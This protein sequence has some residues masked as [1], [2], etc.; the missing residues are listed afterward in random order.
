MRLVACVDSAARPAL[1]ERL[2]LLAETAPTT[3]VE[4]STRVDKHVVLGL[5][6]QGCI[7]YL[8]DVNA[9]TARLALHL[10]KRRV[11]FVLDTGDDPRALQRAMGGGRSSAEAR[12]VVDNLMVRSASL[13]V[14]RGRFHQAQLARRSASPVHWAPDTAPDWLFDAPLAEGDPKVVATFGSTGR[15]RRP[16]ARV[17]GQELVELL[18]LAPD[19]QGILVARGPGVAVLST[20]A[21]ALGVLDRLRI[22]D[23][24]PLDELVRVISEA[25]FI[26]SHQS[27]DRAGWVR[28]TGKLPLALATGRRLIASRV[29]EA[30]SVLPH[31]CTYTADVDPAH[32]V[33]DAVRLGVPEG[34]STTARL[35]AE[36][37]RRSTVARGLRVALAEL[38]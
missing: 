6:E 3:V 4:V 22:H 23:A 13:V 25:A 33:L 14:C 19:L 29:G 10:R 32:G 28:T 37:Y 12:G 34:W 26:T 30:S 21:G 17:Y 24:L 38:H 16:G 18:A 35:L 31:E 20:L 11:P 15:P 9:A 27:D 1:S 5:V 2:A 36:T 7:P 8:L